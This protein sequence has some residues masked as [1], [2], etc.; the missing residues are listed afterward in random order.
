[1]VPFDLKN[2]LTVGL[3]K[4]TT[5]VTDN[6]AVVSGIFDMQGYNGVMWAIVAGSLADADAT[7]TLLVEESTASDMTG[8]T[9][10]SD[11]DL[12]GTEALASFTFSG[13]DSIKSIGYIGAQRYVRLTMTPAANTGSAT[14]TMVS[15]AQA[16]VRGTA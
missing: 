16:A 15:I 11:D 8:A 4:A 5:A 14:F 12:V 1:M 3:A 10:V 2:R 13:D 7:F 9:A 6:T